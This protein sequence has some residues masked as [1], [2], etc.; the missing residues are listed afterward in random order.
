MPGSGSHLKGSRSKGTH[1]NKRNIK[2]KFKGNQFTAENS[3]ELPSSSAKK[4]KS[5]DELQRPTDS[6]IK[7]VILC[8]N[9]VFSTLSQYIKCKKCNGQISFTQQRQRYCIQNLYRVFLWEKIY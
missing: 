4:L 1:R 7:Y 2:R 6:S 5:N 3:S 8:F 9:V